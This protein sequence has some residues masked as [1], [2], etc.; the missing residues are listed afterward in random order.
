[1]STANPGNDRPLDLARGAEPVEPLALSVQAVHKHFGGVVAL[2]GVTFGV[3]EGQIKAIIGP[4]GAGKTTLFNV[5]TGLLRATSGHVTIGGVQVNGRRPWEIAALGV[6]RTFQM[7]ELFENMSVLE[8]VMVGCHAWTKK[9]MFASALRLGG[10][11]EEE[12]LTAERA[13]QKLALVGLAEQAHLGAG[14][15]PFG[16]Q[17]LVEIARALAA[18]PRLLLLDEPAGGLSTAEASAL[19]GLIC[20]L[21][22]AGT[23]ILLVEHDMGLVMDIS[24]E[25]MVLD[26][27]AKLAEGTPND[28]QRDPQVIAA[29][30]GAEEA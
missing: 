27:G 11:L 5:V 29:Y 10:V 6:A 16:Q 3:S 2:N 17:R 23:T 12:K 19:G 25:V 15:L 28:V 30:L 24:D 4:N 1:M 7:L 8:N 22:E 13:M 18:E 20:R 14:E 21:R 26:R 9:G